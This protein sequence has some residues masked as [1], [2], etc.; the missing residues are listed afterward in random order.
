MYNDIG[1]KLKGIASTLCGIVIAIACV[2]GL[3]VMFQSFW[4]GLLEIVGGS[5]IGWCGFAM[6]YAIGELV[7]NS[8]NTRAYVEVIYQT[9]ASGKV[10][11]PE[12]APT[13][14]KS[15]EKEALWY[16]SECGFPNGAEE[17]VCSYCGKQREQ[18]N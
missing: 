7:D 4:I 14:K 1:R 2:S 15:D 8:T 16:C 13:A 5:V 11:V 18:S 9:M 12:V 6:L 17:K 3:I 10:S